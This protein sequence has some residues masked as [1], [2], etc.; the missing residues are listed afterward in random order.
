MPAAV[1]ESAEATPDHE[2]TSEAAAR[3]GRP[4]PHAADPGIRGQVRQ[5]VERGAQLTTRDNLP[6]Y[7]QGLLDRA[8]AQGKI[9]ALESEVGMDMIQR[10]GG[11]IETELAYTSKLNALARE[12]SGEANR[13]QATPAQARAEVSAIGARLASGQFA[14]GHERETLIRD[15]T[16]KATALGAE[17]EVQAMQRLNDIVGKPAPTAAPAGALK[18]QWAIV[19]STS[20][21]DQQAAIEHLMAVIDRLPPGEQH[22][23]LQRLNDLARRTAAAP[24]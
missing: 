23:H 20:G 9:T 17:A 16:D 19:E 8:R 6:Q 18:A 22:D 15:Y 21:T 12:L 2:P 14:D 1:D 7:L 10:V 3:V 11:D 13:P 5:A 4:R 24:R